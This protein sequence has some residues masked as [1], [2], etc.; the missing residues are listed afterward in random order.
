MFV[1][2]YMTH[3]VPTVMYLYRGSMVASGVTLGL[4]KKIV[5]QLSEHLPSFVIF[6]SLE[7]NFR[8]ENN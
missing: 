2:S 6:T 5:L 7:H 8:G 1:L 3:G 4:N